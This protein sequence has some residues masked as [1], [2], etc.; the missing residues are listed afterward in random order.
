LA[1]RIAGDGLLDAANIGAAANYVKLDPEAW[2]GWGSDDDILTQF[3][4]LWHVLVLTG[5]PRSG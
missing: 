4:R 2:R 1:E 5:A 3:R